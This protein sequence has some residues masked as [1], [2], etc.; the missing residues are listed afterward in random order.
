MLLATGGDGTRCGLDSRP[1]HIRA[2]VDAMLQRLDVDGDGGR[3]GSLVDLERG[4]HLLT[5]AT[6]RTSAPLRRAA[7]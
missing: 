1:E 5:Q 6:A 3:H 2:V 4:R 7:K